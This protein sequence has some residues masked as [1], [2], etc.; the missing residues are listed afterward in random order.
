M[1]NLFQELS[2]Y[3]DKINHFYFLEKTNFFNAS[4]ISPWLHSHAVYDDTFSAY[5]K[6][7]TVVALNPFE[8]DWPFPV[9]INLLIIS[10]PGSLP[11]LRMF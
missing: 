10:S 5:F 6:D 7:P 1:Q 9:E 8:L 2:K 3:C 11:L 4:T